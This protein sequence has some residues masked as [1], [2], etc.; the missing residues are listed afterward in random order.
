MGGV[1]QFRALSMEVL[2][3]EV[4]PLE[5]T[6]PKLACCQVWPAALWEPADPGV[7]CMDFY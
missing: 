7:G 4:P 2:K 3:A 1:G 5:I 6:Y